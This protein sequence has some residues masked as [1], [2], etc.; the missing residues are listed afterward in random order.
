MIFSVRQVKI[1]RDGQTIFKTRVLAQ[2]C[3][4]QLSL[5]FTVNVTRRA[6]ALESR[7]AVI[8]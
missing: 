8:A 1:R 6:R 2:N 5:C 7:L 4:A 3:H